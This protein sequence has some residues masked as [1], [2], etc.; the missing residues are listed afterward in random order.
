MKQEERKETKFYQTVLAIAVPVT[1]QS[2]LQSSFG[3]VDQIMTGQLGS[4]CIAGIGL[5]SRFIS[6]FTVLSAA[7]ATV[8][9]IMI[10]QYAGKGDKRLVGRSFWINLFLALGIAAVFTAAGILFPEQIMQLY[11]KDEAVCQAAGGYLRIAALSF[12]PAAVSALISPLLRCMEAAVL[13]LYA[14]IIGA[15]LNTILNY[16]LIFGK[17]GFPKMGISGAAAATAISQAAGCGVMIAFCFWHTGKEKDRKLI[18]AVRMTSEEK[19][20]Y[21][22][23]LLPILACEFAWSMGEN[24]YGMIYGHMGTMPCAAMT[25]TGPVQSLMIGAL[26][27]ISQAAGV[28]IGK[29]LGSAS[30]EKAYEESKK[31]MWYGLAGSLLLSAVL[32]LMRG[33]YVNLYCV[34]NGVKELAVQILLVFALI[35]PVKVQNMIVGGGVIRSGGETKYVM[36]IDIIGTWLFGVPLGMLAAFFLHLRIPYVYLMLSLEECVRLMICLMVFRK[37][38]WMKVLGEERRK[39]ANE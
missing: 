12:L 6:V 28:I 4:S 39:E 14:G 1:L 37:R 26:T 31:L 34:E 30:Y 21:C 33:C 13:P 32:I 22:K 5:A 35:S 15:V 8:A 16:V 20:Q 3:M 25:L 18:F 23:I 38:K 10:A 19:A 36:W 17:A 24:V 7:I 11:T 9:G 27:G 2:L 29:T